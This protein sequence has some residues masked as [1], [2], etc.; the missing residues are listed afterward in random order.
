MSSSEGGLAP[1]ATEPLGAQA[2]ADVLDTGAAGGLVVRGG[3]LRVGSYVAGVLVSVLGASLMFRHLDVVDYGR[4]ATVMAFITIVGALSDLGLTGVGLRQAAVGERG[5]RERI[6]RNIV[7]MRLSTSA[8]GLSLA[9]AFALV[10][11]YPAVVV[12]GILVAGVGLFAVVTLDSYMM[13]LQVGLRLGWTAAL[14]FVRVLGQTL[15]V[16]ALVLAGASLLPF[17]GTQIP[18]ALT[19]AVIAAL[20]VRSSSRLWPSFERSVW[21]SLAREMLPYAAAAAIGAVYFRVE[22]VVLSLT[23]SGVQTGLFGTAFRITE[24]VVGIPW[25]V[26]SSA[27]PVIARAADTDHDRLSYALARMFDASLVAGVGVALAIFLG[28]KFAI[29]LVAGPKYAGSVEV[30][31]I[32]AVTVAFTF[33]MTQWGFALLALKRARALLAVNALGLTVAVLVTVWLGGERGAAGA[34]IALV[35]AEATLAAGY[36]LFL[37]RR[38]QR[39]LALPRGALVRVALAAGAGLAIATAAPISS[40]PATI[41]G[42]GVY[43]LVLAAVGGI[44]PEAVQLLPGRRR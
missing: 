29:D 13:Q 33:L 12:E 8:I 24:V 10:T 17:T 16:V 22:I 7:G 21:S 32:Q 11:G 2:Q 35:C 6:V 9:C 19:A 34:S 41:V 15:A 40:L 42:L 27:L 37:N 18:G 36:A 39:R 43:L 1:A 30:L 26:A 23:S 38:G 44:P 3:T 20:L 4:Y 5:E 25:L 31:Q 28:A 14:E